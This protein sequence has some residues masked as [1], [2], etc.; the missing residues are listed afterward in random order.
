ME[1]HVKYRYW[2]SDEATL[3]GEYSQEFLDKLDE[4]EREE[5][6]DLY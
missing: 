5:F 3:S 4:E 6:T 2:K 1:Y